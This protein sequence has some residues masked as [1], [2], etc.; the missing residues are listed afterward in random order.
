MSSLIIFLIFVKGLYVCIELNS[1]ELMVKW[2]PEY[3]G[4]D[5]F[6]QSQGFKHAKAFYLLCLSSFFC[7]V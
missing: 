5:M 4:P 6:V 7:L 3:Q 1:Y 2:A